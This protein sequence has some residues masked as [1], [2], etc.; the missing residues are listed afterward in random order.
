MSLPDWLEPLP[1]AERMRAT[2][3]WAIEE[4]GVASLD[5]ME[6]AGAGLTALVERVAPDG[7]VA[8][9]CGGG[10]NGGDGFV[11]AR[12]LRDG[13]RDVRVGITVDRDK[14]QGDAAAN[15]ERLPGDPPEPFDASLLDGAAVCVD[16]LLGTGFAGD[17]RE[18]IRAAIVA[19]N[20]CEAPVVAC[21]VPS[22]VDGSTG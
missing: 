7:P 5:L 19:L 9:V 14:Y 6:R 15:L 1:D 3:R 4:M 11:V 13:G 18:P 17:V 16:A 21:D 20:A 12:L 2:D 8:V 10:N 22:G